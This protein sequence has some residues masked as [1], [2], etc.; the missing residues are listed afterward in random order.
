MNRATRYTCGMSLSLRPPVL[1]DAETVAE[2]HVRSWQ[3]G[4]GDLMPADFLAAQNPEYRA[5]QYRDGWENPDYAHVRG[6]VAERHGQV[7]GFVRYGP[8]RTT[9]E[10]GWSAVD[11]SQGG[12]VYALY[13]HP[14]HWGIGAGGQLLQ[15]AVAELTAADQT[16]VRVWTLS[17]NDRTLRFYR[18]H[19]FVSDGEVKLISLGQREKID[20]PEERMTLAMPE[21]PLP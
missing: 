10:A 16:P 6:L 21:Q 13:V 18:R 19:G 9:H 11:P 8:Y 4:Y 5:R 15:A 7:V 20:L 14:D 12:E 3:T 17:G 1:D 2:L